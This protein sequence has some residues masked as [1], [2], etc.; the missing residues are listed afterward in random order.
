MKRF[1]KWLKRYISPMFVVLFIAA[2]ILWYITK[3]SYTYTTEY[4]AKLIIEGERI[5]VPCVIEGVGTNLLSYKYDWGERIEIGLNELNHKIS[6]T[7]DGQHVV[8][9]RPSELQRVLSVKMND[10]KLVSVGEVPTITLPDS[11]QKN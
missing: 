1:F 7:E 4:K 2:F 6:V 3:L 9:I 5:D 8:N 11:Y 10:I